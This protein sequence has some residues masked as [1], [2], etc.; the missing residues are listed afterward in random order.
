MNILFYKKVYFSPQNAPVSIT[1][2]GQKCEIMSLKKGPELI[3]CCPWW[4][5]VGKCG[6]VGQKVAK[7]DEGG[8]TKK[9]T[10]SD[11]EVCVGPISQPKVITFTDG[12]R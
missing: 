5:G 4:G 1:Q 3:H 6:V 8:S 11:E 2:Y 12:P 10:K 9:D 7:I